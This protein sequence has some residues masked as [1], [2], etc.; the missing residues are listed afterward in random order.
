MHPHRVYIF[1]SA[2]GDGS[3]RGVSHH[4]EFYFFEAFYALFHQHLMNRRQLK[5]VYGYFF[6]FFSVFGESAS[7]SAE[8]K[9]RSQDYRVSYPF[10][11][12]LRLFH[13]VGYLRR[14]GR[15]P[16]LLTHLLEQLS[17]LRSLYAG[18][19]GSQKLCAALLEHS[20]FLQLHDQIE[21]CLASYSR[22]YGVR[23]LVSE[24][25]GYVL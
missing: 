22:H 4:L 20:L 6:Q 2:Y 1:H 10:G 18:A 15:L 12:L 11:S 3:V 16:Y 9:G 8:C 14:N 7:R 17:V 25:L 21:A 24:N 5:G 19:A 13:V 23:P